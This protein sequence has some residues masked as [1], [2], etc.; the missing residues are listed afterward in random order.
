MGYVG[1]IGISTLLAWDEASTREALALLHNCVM[2]LSHKWVG[3]LVEATDEQVHAVFLDAVDTL[4]WALVPH[5]A[6]MARGG[7]RVK[8]GVDV[9]HVVGEVHVLTGWICYRGKMVPCAAR[10]M[11]IASSNQVLASSK[12]WAAALVSASSL[13]QSCGVVDDR[14][15]PFKLRGIADHVEMVQVRL[16][17]ADVAGVDGWAQELQ[18]GG[19]GG[20]S[21]V[22]TREVTGT[23]GDGGSA[24]IASGAGRTA[25]STM[26]PAE[27]FK[28]QAFSGDSSGV[29]ERSVSGA[30]GFSLLSR[31][32]H[33][34]AASAPSRSARR[35]RQ[36]HQMYNVIGGLPHLPQLS[37]SP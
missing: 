6:P 5:G 16:Q 4:L 20:G 7:L 10:V 3:Y 28:W 23:D 35:R 18:E 19:V 13:L 22:V 24:V 11:Q 12:A 37:G 25:A 14:L 32:S 31:A 15:G 26:Q 34:G 17:R 8:T 27:T 2:E 30:R 21:P 33:G 36:H 9:G 29:A 1:I